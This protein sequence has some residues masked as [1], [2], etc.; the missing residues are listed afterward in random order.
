MDF[1]FIPS[2]RG[3]RKEADASSSKFVII[4]IAILGAPFCLHKLFL[5][6]FWQFVLAVVFSW[7]L[8]PTVISVIDI[9]ILLFTS[10]NAYETKYPNR[11]I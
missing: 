5:C 3:K 6:K 9:I 7:T 11:I 1:F 10:S 8:I 4:V 2:Y